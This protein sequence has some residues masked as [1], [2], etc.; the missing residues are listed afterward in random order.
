M[1]QPVRH[2]VDSIDRRMRRLLLEGREGQTERE[3]ERKKE[4]NRFHQHTYVSIFEDRPQEYI[5]SRPF[6]TST[7][8]QQQRQQQPQRR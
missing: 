1:S 8:Q 2:F 6:Y 5:V 7:E 4:G 3:R